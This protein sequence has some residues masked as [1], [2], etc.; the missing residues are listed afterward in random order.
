MTP[1][2]FSDWLRIEAAEPMDALDFA[3]LS[4]V[5]RSVKVTCNGGCHADMHFL[6]LCSPEGSVSP[7][8]MI[9][10]HFGQPGA[11]SSITYAPPHHPPRLEGLNLIASS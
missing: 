6:A 8:S 11:L 10:I 2:A 4:P 1:E 9:Q 5:D 3:P 7:L